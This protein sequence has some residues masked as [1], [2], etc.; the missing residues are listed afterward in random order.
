[1]GQPHYVNETN[2]LRAIARD[3]KCR[4]R[5]TKHALEEVA[6]D[7]RTTDDVEHSLMN[8][9]VILQ[10]EKKDRL[11]RSIGKDIDGNRIQ[12]VVAVYEEEVMIKIIT[13][14]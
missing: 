8:G 5:W 1:M 4:F 9:Q 10:E 13:T 12:V 11:W 2:T 3:K 14:F 6:K 7:G